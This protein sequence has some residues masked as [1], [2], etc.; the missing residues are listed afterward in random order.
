MIKIGDKVKFL[1]DIGGGVVTGFTGNNTAIVEN[2]DGFDIPYPVSML[3]NVDDPS[4]NRPVAKGDRNNDIEVSKP[5]IKKKV[6]RTIL[7]G[8][9]APDFYFCF[10]PSDSKNPLAADIELFFVND[11]NYNILLRYAHQKDG[12]FHTRYYGK[13]LPNSKKL[14]EPIGINDLGELPD[15]FFQVIF[16]MDQEVQFLT[17]I[18]KMIKVS[19]IKFYKEKS[20]QAVS[21]FNRNA[22]VF[23]VSN[24]ILDNELDKISDDEFR[25]IVRNKEKKE[26]VVMP[27]VV[28]VPDIIE[29]DLHVKELLDNSSGLSNK[30]ILDIQKE[31]VERE[32]KSAIKSGAK[33][34]VFIHGVG[35]GV[36]KLEIAKL[37]KGKFSKY[38]FHDASFKEYG[39]G[40]TMVIL[41]KG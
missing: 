1:N 7:K 35:Q 37:L 2:Q 20:Y 30:E 28:K 16:F 10:V 36:L 25:K 31:K 21:F 29:I 32:M 24:N 27:P 11:S 26:D 12:L 41:R 9:D 40:A 22:M 34:I 4:L 38:S 19:P 3:I 15:Y 39:F 33:R 13:V 5:V 17:P 23:K 18:S 14:L 8:K 6:T